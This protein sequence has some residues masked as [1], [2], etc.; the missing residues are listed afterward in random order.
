[1]NLD[2]V[3]PKNELKSDTDS[4][5]DYS[6][7]TERGVKLSATEILKMLCFFNLVAA[8]QIFI[9]YINIYVLF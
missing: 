3:Y 5:S 4:D 6:D 2:Y 1:M 7:E 9:L 8:F